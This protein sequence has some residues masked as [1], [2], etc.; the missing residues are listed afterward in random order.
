MSAAA[1]RVMCVQVC[2]VAH[3]LGI[4]GACWWWVLL[5]VGQQGRLTHTT[6]EKFERASRRS[7]SLGLR[8]RSLGL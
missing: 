3:W 6:S 5:L 7:M 2:N 8:E 4:S 1:P